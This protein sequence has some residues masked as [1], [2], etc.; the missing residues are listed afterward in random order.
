M[1]LASVTAMPIA[2]AMAMRVRMRVLRCCI[3][4]RTRTDESSFPP[5]SPLSL[6]TTTL[7]L[8]PLTIRTL[9]GRQRQRQQLNWMCWHYINYSTPTTTDVLQLH[10]DIPYIYRLNPPFPPIL[11]AT[12]IVA[13][14]EHCNWC[15]NLASFWAIVDGGSTTDVC[16]RCYVTRP[17]NHPLHSRCRRSNL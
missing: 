3:G 13:E 12:V 1:T 11:T 10:A 8:I 4:A 15:N 5:C 6:C 16:R 9:S 2:N 17:L 14:I 7:L